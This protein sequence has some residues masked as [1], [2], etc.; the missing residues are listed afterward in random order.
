MFYTELPGNVKN[1]SNVQNTCQYTLISWNEPETTSTIVRHYM[2]VVES[3]TICNEINKCI[4]PTTNFNLTKLNYGVNYTI[5]VSACSC[6]G[7]GT[8]TLYHYTFDGLTKK[9]SMHK[10]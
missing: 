5:S 6:D 4:S 1:I 7:C 2:V 3:S 9:G 10:L 8:D